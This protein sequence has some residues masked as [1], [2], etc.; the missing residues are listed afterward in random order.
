MV[1]IL[2][3]VLPA[4][5]GGSPLDY[6]LMEAE[7]DRGFT[8]LYLLVSP[9]LKLVNEQAVVD[10]VLA[11]L[12]ASSTMADAARVGWQHARTIQI[13]RQEPVSNGRGKLLPLHIQ[14]AGAS[15]EADSQ[16]PLTK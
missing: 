14:R 3:E 11:A 7:D 10:T 13:K 16:V 15:R 1:R 2:E 8:R 12:G 4:R 6:Q 9:R 5:F